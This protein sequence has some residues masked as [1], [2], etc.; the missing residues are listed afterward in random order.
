LAKAGA[1]KTELARFARLFPHGAVVN[2]AT[3]RRA[4]R[5]GLP[6]WWIVNRLHLLGGNLETQKVLYELISPLRR[7][8]YRG[9]D[10]G[11]RRENARLDELLLALGIIAVLD[12]R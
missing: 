3:V 5:G 4:V 7:V 10:G 12:L 8:V 9:C 2:A 6:M 11:L 1:C